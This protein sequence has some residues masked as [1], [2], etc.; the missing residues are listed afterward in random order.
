M[1]ITLSKQKSLSIAH[2]AAWVIASAVGL[3]M[4]LFGTLFLIWNV[5]E[6]LTTSLPEIVVAL[7]GGA[8]VGIG[9]GGLVGVAQWFV[10]RGYSPQAGRWYVGSILGGIVAGTAAILI[11][12]FNDGGENTLI[13]LLAFLV[14]GA[15]L[16]M[17]QYLAAG[18]IARSP[19]WVAASAVG[20]TLAAALSFGMPGQ[21]L[22]WW[23][24]LAGGLL[25]GAVTAGV[26][27]WNE[28]QA[29]Q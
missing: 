5:A 29:A 28:R 14:L 8:I 24:L 4:G 10:L 6:N 11:S 21:D 22:V 9:V 27:V 7:F 15:L 12:Q 25:Y 19:W 26:L 20:L 13:S 17:G 1:N 16:G 3:V 2:L 18:S 23:N